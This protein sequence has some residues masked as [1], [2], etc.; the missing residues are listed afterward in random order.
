[1]N[2]IRTDEGGRRTF[3]KNGCIAVGLICFA[4]GMRG[5]DSQTNAS[6]EDHPATHNMLVVGHDTIFLSHLP[7]FQ[8][9]NATKAAFTSPHRYQVCLLYT[10]PS[11]R[12]S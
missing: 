2:T 11:P 3:V 9:V 12:D 5:A 8:G 6:A 1:M 7:M 4:A 10:S